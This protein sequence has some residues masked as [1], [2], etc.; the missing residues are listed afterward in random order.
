MT[1]KHVNLPCTSSRN[2]R[3]AIDA[4]VCAQMR[5]YARSVLYPRIY[6]C[7]YCVRTRAGAITYTSF[8]NIQTYLQ[9]NF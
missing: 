5:M 2:L 8:A 1:Q 3:R 4:H 7:V 9:L 6:V